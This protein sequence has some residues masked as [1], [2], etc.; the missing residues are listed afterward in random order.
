MVQ[1]DRVLENKGKQQIEQAEQKYLKIRARYVKK[2]G[3]EPEH[4]KTQEQE[5]WA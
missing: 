4:C 1:D 2:F 3:V 5:A